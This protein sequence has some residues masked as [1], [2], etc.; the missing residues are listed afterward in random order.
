MIKEIRGGFVLD[1]R[2]PQLEAGP[3]HV[4]GI[5]TAIVN[6]LFAKSKGGDFILRVEDTDSKREVEGAIDYIN[7]SF[8][9]IGIEPT[10]GYGFG[11]EYGPY[12]QSDRKE[13]YK[14]HVDV[15]VD[16]GFA[17][18][19]F[20]TKEEL[21]KMRSDM[22]NSGVKNAG[23]TGSVRDRMRNSISLPS[24]EVD[25]LL[26]SGANYVI[27]FKMPRSKDVKFLDKIR[28]WIS[29]N[30]KDLDD[31]VIW[32]SSDGL[33]TY[34]MANVIDDHLMEISHV[35]RGEE[36]VSSTPLHILLY[37]S[38]GWDLP[39]FAHLPLIL[40]PDGKKLGKRNKYGIP[41]FA[42]DWTYTTPAPESEVVSING[43]KEA[44]YEPDALFN[45]L[46]LL[47]WNPGDN[48]EIMSR[49]EI[50]NSFS[51]DRVNK[52]G[53]MFDLDKLKSFNSHYLKNR[54]SRDII[55]LMNI[56]EETAS[57]LSNDKLN[58]IAEMATERAVFNTD[59]GG[60]M[61]YLYNRPDLSGELKVKNIDEFTKFVSVF[62][63]EEMIEMHN[64][65]DWNPSNI[66]MEMNSIATN[67]GFKLGKVMPMLRLAL[68]GGVP[69]P[70]LPDLMFILGKEETKLRI[71][72]LLSELKETTEDV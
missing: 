58:L 69:G 57:S 47:G 16:S 39:E 33:P 41:V 10:E 13:I 17:Y 18:Y 20:D 37:E 34:H 53:A 49:E 14:K 5:K 64:D 62:A 56:P 43:F 7:R 12:K 70:Q 42:L 9:Y 60:A 11:G 19:A 26:S 8:E 15:L 44:G 24:S 28:G 54:N 50:V 31:K 21:D 22:K 46:C 65:S 51:L 38:F 63:S 48:R 55:N 68:T 27:R 67:L 61:S 30:T 45:F 59:L 71:D 72:N 52:A 32:K 6:Y 2:P 29:F 3:L 23:Y 25:N 66:R 4:G 1:L 35:I 40:G 36:W